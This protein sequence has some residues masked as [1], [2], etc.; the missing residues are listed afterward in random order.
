M[1][2]LMTAYVDGRD[3][4]ERGNPNQH[5]TQVLLLL[6][7][8]IQNTLTGLNLISALLKDFLIVHIV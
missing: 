2:D 1:F 3:E 7:I 6:V 5:F 8:Y 4:A